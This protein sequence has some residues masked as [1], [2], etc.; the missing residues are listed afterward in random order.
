MDP[1]LFGAVAIV[2][3]LSNLEDDL[4]TINM[5]QKMDQLQ[6]TGQIDHT[7]NLLTVSFLFFLQTA[8]R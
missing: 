7:F 1:L 4:L 5:E 3:S 6:P 2:A 8:F